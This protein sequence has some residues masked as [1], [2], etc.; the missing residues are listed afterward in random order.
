MIGLAASVYFKVDVGLVY[1][2]FLG[3]TTATICWSF[4]V[5]LVV[6]I[7]ACVQKTGLSAEGNTG[8]KSSSQH[9]NRLFC[10]LIFR[11]TADKTILDIS[12]KCLIKLTKLSS[13]GSV[14]RQ[15]NVSPSHLS[16]A[17]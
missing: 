16:L 4:F 1:D 12:S 13:F 9:F 5:A 11:Y 15:K 14:L 7:K 8:I 10:S 3:I 6:Y 17:S 2:T